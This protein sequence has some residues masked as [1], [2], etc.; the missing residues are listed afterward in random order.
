[1]FG[2]DFVKKRI[3][4]ELTLIDILQKRLSTDE[5]ADLKAVLAD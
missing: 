4:I 3:K 2:N 5:F 1:M